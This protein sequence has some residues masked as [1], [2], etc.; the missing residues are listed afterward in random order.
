MNK[1]LFAPGSALGNAFN[2]IFKTEARDA[3]AGK[4]VD[5]AVPVH[6]TPDNMQNCSDVT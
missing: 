3:E 4:R 6:A 5:A 1:S 2:D